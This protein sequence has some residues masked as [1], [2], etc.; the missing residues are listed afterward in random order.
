MHFHILAEI[1]HIL[2]EIFIY[3]AER[4]SRAPLQLFL[5]AAKTLSD[6]SLCW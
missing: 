3:L 1:F 6:S 4:F 2:A 5:P